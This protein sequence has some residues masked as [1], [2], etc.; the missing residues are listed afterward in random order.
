MTRINVGIEPPEVCDQMLL[1]AYREILR[2]LNKRY[3]ASAPP[4]HF[5]LNDGHVIWCAQFPRMLADMLEASVV[6]LQYRGFSPQYTRAPEYARTSTLV[7]PAFEVARA[8]P[9]LVERIQLRLLEARRIPRW[10][11]REPPDWAVA[12][13]AEI[14]TRPLPDRCRAAA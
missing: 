7:P 2:P 8:R 6:E 5:K 12:S 11:G 9:L 13:G 3:Y 1:A 14:E 4:P 10:T